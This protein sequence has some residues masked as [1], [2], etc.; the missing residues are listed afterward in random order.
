MWL[1]PA[2]PPEPRETQEMLPRAWEH[3]GMIEMLV[4][5]D[6]SETR[7]ALS[8]IVGSRSTSG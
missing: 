5:G 1:L 2:F 7:K 8:V 6:V 4:E 3:L